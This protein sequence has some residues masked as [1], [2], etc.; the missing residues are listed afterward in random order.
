MYDYDAAL[1]MLLT[2][3]DSIAVQALSVWKVKRWH[4]TDL[5]RVRRFELDLLGEISGGA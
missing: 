1:K 2:E 4:N 5:P 3:R